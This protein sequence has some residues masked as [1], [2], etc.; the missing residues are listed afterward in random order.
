MTKGMKL[1]KS[2]MDEKNKN[3][4]FHPSNAK[5]NYEYNAKEDIPEGMEISYIDGNPKNWKFAN[6]K[7]VA[8]DTTK[9][10]DEKEAE[11][12]RKVLEKQ[13]E[14]KAKEAEKA[15]IKAEKELAKKEA[16]KIKKDK[17]TLSKAIK[18]KKAPKGK[19]FVFKDGNEE[20]F[21][22]DNVTL[23]AK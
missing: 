8:E 23:E 10:K 17:E 15:R 5:E 6:L 3:A 4:G 19:V 9:I 11:K 21:K 20:N 12:A 18:E 14:K 7:L 1:G 22:K 16:D 13:E 2:S